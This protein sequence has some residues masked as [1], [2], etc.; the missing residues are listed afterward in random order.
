M[1]SYLD[2]NLIPGEKIIYSGHR[3]WIVFGFPCFWLLVAAI[4]YFFTDFGQWIALFFV[5]VAVFWG[6]SAWIDYQVTEIYLTNE[7]ILIKTGWIARSSLE[8][9]LTRISSIDVIQTFW[10]R[11]LNFGTV[12]ICDVGN[13]RTPF[14]RIERPFIFRRAVL[15][16]IDKRR[17]EFQ[18]QRDDSGKGD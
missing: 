3:H 15:T 9:D 5:A 16:E 18:S 8:T 6:M 14:A 2:K 1:S 4:L 13:A 17:E 12:I 10:G 11:I 7:R